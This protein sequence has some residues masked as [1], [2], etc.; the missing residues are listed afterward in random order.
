MSDAA[1][2]LLV[3]LIQLL[4][5]HLVGVGSQV[6]LVL[7]DGGL[8]LFIDPGY[9]GDLCGGKLAKTVAQATARNGHDPSFDRRTRP[10]NASGVGLGMQQAGYDCKLPV[11][12]KKF[13]VRT[14]FQ[15]LMHVPSVG[16]ADLP[17]LLGLTALR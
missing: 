13:D 8:A 2:L 11:P 9:V 5:A 12:F 14:I 7:A 17:G 15:G 6:D 16:N 4:L 3:E 1:S 10:V